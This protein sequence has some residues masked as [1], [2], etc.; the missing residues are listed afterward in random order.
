MD[1]YTAKNKIFNYL[2]KIQ[3]SNIC[4]YISSFVKKNYAKEVSEIVDL[5]LEEQIYYLDISSSRF[6][7][8]EDYIEN[9]EFRRDLEFYIKENQKKCI[10]KE[11]QKPIYEKQ[12]AFAKEQRKKAQEIKMSKQPPTKAQISYYKSLCKKYGME[13][14]LDE[15]TSSRLDY[16]NAISI[17]L[18]KTD[19][20]AKPDLSVRFKE[21][22]KNTNSGKM[23]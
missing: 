12:K 7:W 8:I 22:Y 9:E 16:K 21:F 19:S 5:F 13:K 23:I 3:K 10:Y 18:E 2:T 15:K 6:P 17:I 11:K 1:I 20:Q 4:H 14:V